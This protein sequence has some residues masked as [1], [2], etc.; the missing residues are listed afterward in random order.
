MVLAD[1]SSGFLPGLGL[2]LGDCTQNLDDLSR[3]PQELQSGH[4]LQFLE[5]CPF[6]E[7]LAHVNDQAGQCLERAFLSLRWPWMSPPHAQHEG[8]PEEG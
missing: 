6:T 2:R 7:H 4:L 5:K 1:V 8:L 3:W